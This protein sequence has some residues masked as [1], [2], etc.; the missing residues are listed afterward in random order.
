MATIMCYFYPSLLTEQD[1][2]ADLRVLGP[3]PLEVNKPSLLTW[4]DLKPGDRFDH[5]TVYVRLSSLGVEVKEGL[6]S[7]ILNGE[8]I[9]YLDPPADP[10]P[11]D[12]YF[13]SHILT[14][15]DELY[16][17]EKGPKIDIVGPTRLIWVDFRGMQIGGHPTAY[18]LVSGA[19]VQ[20]VS[21]WGRPFLNGHYIF[22]GNSIPLTMT[23]PMAVD[24]P[25]P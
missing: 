2:L 23:L 21:G 20:V 22:D 11:I 1:Q 24:M 3:V 18:V 7:P 9:L 14:E 12:C 17:D 25:T 8:R 19:G 6:G 15:K 13:Y 5:A 16:D 10:T 4:L